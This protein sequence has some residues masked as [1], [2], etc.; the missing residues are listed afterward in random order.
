[1]NL[2]QITGGKR[3]KVNAV[4]FLKRKVFRKTFLILFF[5]S[6]AD[7]GSQCTLILLGVPRLTSKLSN[8]IVFF[9]IKAIGQ[10]LEAIRI[11]NQEDGKCQTYH[12]TL[13]TFL[14]CNEEG[15]N[16]NF[17]AWRKVIW[18]KVNLRQQEEGKFVIFGGRLIHISRRKVHSC[19]LEEGILSPVR[20]R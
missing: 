11:A 3:R 10:A 16:K 8:H 13:F 17:R 20:G 14:I 6:H 9:D 1:M 5:A 7:Q 15:N 4:T 19:F 18:R 2:V 12:V